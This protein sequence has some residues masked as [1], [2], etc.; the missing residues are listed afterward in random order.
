MRGYTG[1]RVP[2]YP[3]RGKKESGD[4]PTVAR[5]PQ[6]DARG[7]LFAPT[8]SSTSTQYYY[9]RDQCAGHSS[10][11]SHLKKQFKTKLNY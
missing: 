8:Y 4:K 1:T 6:G 5:P 7:S 3:V 10:L 2:G 9:D 11:E